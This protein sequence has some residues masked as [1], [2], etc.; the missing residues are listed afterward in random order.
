M[1]HY[2]LLY[3]YVPDI[4]E[5]RAPHRERHLARIREQREA[6]HVGL[7]GALGDPPTGG[8]IEFHDVDRAHVE[9]FAREDPY[10]Q[11]GLITA[12]RI[13]PWTLV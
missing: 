6:G 4:A 1:S 2:L 13:E 12:W 7:A 5:R 8:A 9:A 11:A 3:E 10:M